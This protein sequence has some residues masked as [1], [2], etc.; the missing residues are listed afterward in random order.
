MCT[1]QLHSHTRPASPAAPARAP[2]AHVQNMYLKAR[3]TIEQELM[4]LD[5]EHIGHTRPPVDRRT[6]PN[7]L[8]GLP[9]ARPRLP[10]TRP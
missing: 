2:P 7:T 5:H 3:I 10:C 8:N 9:L 6:K 1:D 4:V